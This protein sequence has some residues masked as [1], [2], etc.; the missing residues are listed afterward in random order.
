MSMP[1]PPVENV[2][3]TWAEM[4]AR[5]TTREPVVRVLL[6]GA[7]PAQQ[8]V[9]AELLARL[10]VD[11]EFTQDGV[12]ASRVAVAKVFDVVLIDVDSSLIETLLVTLAIRRFELSTP[13]R[14][15]I[16]VVAYTGIEPPNFESMLKLAG[17]ND[18]LR[19]AN[20]AAGMSECLARWC[21]GKFQPRSL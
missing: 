18:V 15:P 17:A 14:R 2:S 8:R 10:C 7:Q 11:S 1:C 16:P 6:S 19:K 13:S 4:P 5:V 21:P 20:A 9:T 3:A 12:E